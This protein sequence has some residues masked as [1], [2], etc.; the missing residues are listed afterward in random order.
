VLPTAWFECSDTKRWKGRAVTESV[1]KA[2]S[3]LHRGAVVINSE[4]GSF[5]AIKLL[6]GAAADS[7]RCTSALNRNRMKV[8]TGVKYEKIAEAVPVNI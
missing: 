4:D 3:G 5:S 8:V 6:P 2:S 7:E 1:W